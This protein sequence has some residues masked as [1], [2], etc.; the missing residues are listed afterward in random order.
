MSEKPATMTPEQQ[1]ALEEAKAKFEE[2][3]TQLGRAAT[4]AQ[5]IVRQH[6]AVAREREVYAERELERSREL[7]ARLE[8]QLA[9]PSIAEHHTRITMLA[10]IYAEMKAMMTIE[11]A[12]HERNLTEVAAIPPLEA[13]E[14][15]EANPALTASHDDVGYR[16]HRTRMDVALLDYHWFRNRRGLDALLRAAGIDQAG[17]EVPADEVEA[18][19]SAAQTVRDAVA[20]SQEVA[21]LIGR[22]GPEL[23]E[24]FALL[25]WA[26]DSMQSFAQ[27]PL[28][29][30][31][32]ALS[33]A[34]WLKVN[35]RLQQIMEL[36]DRVQAFPALAALFPYRGASN[37]LFE[38]EPSLSG[39]L[40]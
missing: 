10:A 2:L 32:D 24:A 31:R 20:S 9:H 19:E 23:E 39:G 11:I 3:K 40:K 27:L 38:N 5:G 33:D 29:A 18:Q 26:K 6:L 34:D 36:G 14:D 1:Q 8:A 16:E 35:A 15:Y 37:P 28:A 4:Q 17:Y 21:A 30:K 25:D 13:R 7:Q 22:L 12:I